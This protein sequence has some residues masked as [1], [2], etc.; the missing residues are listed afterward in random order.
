M[1]RH[2]RPDDD[3]RDSA[4]GIAPPH[5]SPAPVGDTAAPQS[6]PDPVHS[7]PQET[8]AGHSHGA[9]LSAAAHL[10]AHGYRPDGTKM[11][12]STSRGPWSRAQKILAGLLACAAILTGVGLVLLFPDDSPI[13]TEGAL[14][15]NSQ[16]SHEAVSGTVISRQAGT[17]SSPSVGRLFETDPAPGEP[18]APDACQLAVVEL[19]DGS[20]AGLHTLLMV[21]NT[22]GDPD[23]QVGEN[24]LLSET[25]TVEGEPGYTFLDYQ[26]SI[27]LTM[28]VLLTALAVAGIG[29]LVG[30]RSLFGLA[31]TL[32]VVATV[33]LP[34]LLH[35]EDPLLLALVCGATALFLALYIVHGVTWKT[36]SALAGTLLALVCATGLARFGIESIHLRGLG[37]EDNLLIQLYLPDVTVQGLMLAGFIIGS[38]GVLNDVTISQASTVNELANADPSAR[39]WRLFTAAI[40]VGRDHIASIMY[41]LV[42]GYTG[43]ALPLLLLLTAAGRPLSQ[44]LTSDVLATEILR[45]AIGALALCLAVPLTTLIAALTTTRQ[46]ADTANAPAHPGMIGK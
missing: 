42:L 5:T 19:T 1:G 34:G 9:G 7:Q 15:G 32:G 21:S 46:P 3:Q 11:P 41:T 38:L 20:Y 45:S 6:S 22:P 39:P 10:A 29:G 18:G 24:I 28:W 2:S 13:R 17:C 30:L 8:H 27:G 44:V 31:I 12:R 14:Q 43:A 35:G 36:S 4:A 16:F 33:L 23:L 25:P 37:S 26:R 40:R